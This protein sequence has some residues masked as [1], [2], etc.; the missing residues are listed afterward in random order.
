MQAPKISVIDDLTL[1]ER[2]VDVIESAIPSSSVTFKGL[3]QTPVPIEDPDQSPAVYEFESM[4]IDTSADDFL[5]ILK[6]K[7]SLNNQK[8]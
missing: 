6:Q 3:N 2:S 4:Y 7:K 8:N 1:N 5:L